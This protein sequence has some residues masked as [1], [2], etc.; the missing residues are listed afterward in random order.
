MERESFEDHEVAEILN[1]NFVS[2]KVDREERPDIDQVY[3]SICQALTNHGGWPMTIIMTPDKNPFFAGTYF[4]KHSTRGMSGIVEILNK[5]A[6]MWEVNRN[7]IIDAGKY[8][9]NAIQT[10]N[11]HQS[12]SAISESTIQEAFLNFRSFFDYEY[13]GFGTAP[14]FPAPHNISF[15]LRY[16][17][18]N[19]SEEALKM[20][21]KTLNSMYKGGIFD[22]IGFGFS[23][24]STDKKWLAPHFEK[25]L[26][27]NAL[28]AIA[29]LEA[30]QATG[31][32]AYAEISEKIFTYVLRNMTSPDGGFYSAEDAD[33]EGEEG[34]F[35]LWTPAEVMSIL[36]HS[37]G[38]FFC[39][40]F[41]ISENG[42]FEGKNIPNLI[43]TEFETI[44]R[45]QQSRLY[46]LRQKLFEHREN[47][48][49]P[50]KDDKI[51]T[52][53]NGL[54][55]AALAFG[56]RVLGIR[57]YAFA[58]EKAISFIFS[59]LRD[60]NGRLQARFRDGEAAF[61]A[62]VDDYSFLI[63]GL[64]E[65][66]EATYK[67]QYLKQAIELND[68]LLKLFWD[69]EHGGLY[70]YGYDSEQL[71]SRPKEIYD[72][73][74]PSGNSVSTLNFLRLAR[75]TG[76]H[77]LENLAEQQFKYFGGII[78]DIPTGYS[79]FLMSLLFATSKTKEIVIAGDPKSVD[80][81][82]MLQA[83][84][85]VFLP[86]TIFHI[87][88]QDNN[89]KELT[90]L[91]PFIANQGRVNDSATAYICEDFSCQA[92]VTDIDKFA[93]ILEEQIH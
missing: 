45:E 43:N 53:W 25:M 52:S 81:K 22:H 3:M 86:H 18:V 74:I 4:P 36:G 28:L 78:K 21:E 51:L 15:L 38:K 34:K 82:T 79:H 71:I 91:V 37:D 75:L 90:D 62:Y 35:Y 42:N 89:G 33:S 70:F 93:D 50:Y 85:D 49:H 23:R 72:G 24:Y 5:V 30:Y 9:V 80:T 84:N 88:S 76:M 66:Y 56:S 64:I 60:R 10:S 57:E 54:M 39:K 17:K 63:W 14:K 16:W 7:D 55:I 40:L 61:P 32:N 73:A 31:K 44:S 6:K 87:N 58:A 41:D 26:Y 77:E 67:V 59:S 65:L 19:E 12:K 13:G 29:Y 47:R 92:P 11:Q 83:I 1:A 20:V 68:E 27:D 48:V 69:K 46:L 2:I 8:V